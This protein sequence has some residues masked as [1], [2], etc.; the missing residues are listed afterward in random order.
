MDPDDQ[1]A[2][3]SLTPVGQSA[4]RSAEF[5][6]ESMIAALLPVSP[7]LFWV[8]DQEGRCTWCNN[9]WLAL[10]GTALEDERGRSWREVLH[11]EDGDRCAA[12]LR[13]CADSA[14][15][16]HLEFRL[17]QADGLYA[18]IRATLVLRRSGD[19]AFAGYLGTGWDV[20][21]Q[22]VAE[23]QLAEARQMLAETAES[24]RKQAERW[25]QHLLE[26]AP[27]AL[28][29]VGRSGEMLLV[30]RQTEAVF[31]YP[32]EALIGRPIEL[33]VPERVRPAHAAHRD[34]FFARPRI[35]PMYSTPGL[36]GRHQDG[37]EF[38]V[39]ISLSPVE[40]PQGLVV[41]C[42]IRDITA[43]VRAE[44]LLK[45]RQDELAHVAR[46]A[47][48]GEMATGLAH[49]LNQPLYSISNYARGCLRRLDADTLEPASLRDVL[50]EIAT[51]SDRAAKII[52]R[53][54]RMV[55]KRE[56]VR[57]VLNLNRAIEDACALCQADLKRH[58]VNLERQLDTAL[59]KTYAD[60]VQIQQV[61]LNLLRNA[62]EAVRDAPHEVRRVRIR[63]GR[64]SG[65]TLVVS[66][67]DMGSGI[68]EEDL[69][70]VFDA[71]YTTRPAGMG[72]GL[73][74]SRSIVE[75]HGGR[76]WAVNE[77]DCGATFHFTLPICDAPHHGH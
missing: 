75:M 57:A 34:A 62:V 2:A 63:T 41:A 25:F 47:T 44:Q 51:E 53:L 42:A 73:A 46:L 19:G 72:M 66:V 67:S 38:P 65:D 39:D 52:R 28:I 29:L 37:H 36:Y 71:F 15:P 7:A 31:G 50:A 69:D 4:D 70:R 9:A 11:P 1:F 35:R 43:R 58:A 54:R 48:M 21:A 17:L 20:T 18:S 60:E 16:A 33:L 74:I 23:Q 12:E 13:R 22:Q 24:E 40:A 32:R 45:Q 14:E 30:N 3:V 64:S 68:R 49:E 76:I 6:L 56:P 55:Q 27:D 61:V 10:R 5:V 77:P 8:W 59:P 26:S